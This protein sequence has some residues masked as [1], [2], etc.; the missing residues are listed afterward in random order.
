VNIR[1]V[2]PAGESEL[3]AGKAAEAAVV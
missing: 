1:G 2:R 3:F